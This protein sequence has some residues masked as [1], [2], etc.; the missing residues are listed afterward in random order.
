MNPPTIAA[1]LLIC[2]AIGIVVAKVIAFTFIAALGAL[3]IGGAWLLFRLF[4]R[5]D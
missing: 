3:T 4:R 1:F 5:K 2:V